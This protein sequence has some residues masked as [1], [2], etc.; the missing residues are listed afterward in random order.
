MKTKK[1]KPIVIT[2]YAVVLPDDPF[3]LQWFGIRARAAKYTKQ[4]NTELK[5]KNSKR[6]FKV[7]KFICK[8][9]AK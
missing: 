3:F 1:R 2:Q 6:R 9:V 7:I 8:E 4:L 5:N